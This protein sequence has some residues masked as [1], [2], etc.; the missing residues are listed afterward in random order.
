MSSTDILK[1]D[2]SKFSWFVWK[3]VLRLPPPDR[4][5]LDIG[6]WLATG[7]ERRV[8]HAFRGVGKSFLTCAYVVWR[9]WKN[10]Q[11]KVLIVSA[12]EDLALENAT[13]IQQIIDHPAGND[14]WPEL[15][16]RRG[17]RTSTLSFDVGAAQE[18][19]DKTPSVKCAGINGQITGSRAN[20]L[21]G[22]DVEIPKNSGTELQREKLRGQTREFGDIVKPGEGEII[23]LGTPQTEESIYKDLP[24][25]GY[26]IRIWTARYPLSAKLAFYGEHLAPI[27][28][29]DIEANPALMKAASSSVGGEPTNPI[30]F[31]DVE[32]MKKELERGAAG[33]LLQYQLDTTLT[34]AE[35][36]PLKTRDFIVTDVD[37]KIA[38]LRL[39]WGQD[40]DKVFKD[41]PNVGFDGDRLFRP[42]FASTDFVP[43][44]GAALHID[45]SGRGKDRT[46]Y[47]V[48]KFLNGLVFISRWGGFKD[49]YTEAT[50]RSLAET[51][52][53]E[54]VNHIGVED[55]FGDGMFTALL[56]PVVTRVY[57][58]TVEGYKVSGMKEQRIMAAVRPALQGHRLVLDTTAARADLANPSNV[59]RGLYQLTHL[60]EQRGAL[61]HDDLIDVLAQ[62]LEYWAPYMNADAAKAEDRWKRKQE[63]AFEKEFFRGTIIGDRMDNPQVKRGVGRPVGRA[64]RRKSWGDA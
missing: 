42:I 27:L 55:N 5:Q 8:I 32:L 6:R 45:P 28:Q 47:V 13:L 44:T 46:A 16:S 58:V 19:P 1:D 22:D 53:D 52:R 7:P 62:A 12:G 61:K 21:I 34:D 60:T 41:L 33:F 43:F 57:P 49:G 24:A 64:A 39:V 40:P 3:Y 20:L 17:Q 25:R 4:I 37:S 9:L 59:H 18:T 15:R 35:R 63:E 30:R 10:P 48:T 38:P 29:A 31:N 11:I 2:F 54:E 51:A 36:Y 14:L 56:E 23:W 26:S 50:L